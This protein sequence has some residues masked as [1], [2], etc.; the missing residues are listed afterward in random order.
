MHSGE[1]GIFRVHVS[2]D[3][4]DPF[5]PGRLP[6]RTNRLMFVFATSPSHRRPLL[7]TSYKEV[8]MHAS[9]ARRHATEGLGPNAR[10][11]LEAFFREATA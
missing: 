7:P 6:Q 10:E 5:D 9:A 11:D 1:D 2:M 3:V 4:I 8:L